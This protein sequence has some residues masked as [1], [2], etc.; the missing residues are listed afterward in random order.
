MEKLYSY[1]NMSYTYHSVL[2]VA[3]FEINKSIF[4]LY[5]ETVNTDCI[6]QLMQLFE[7]CVKRFLIGCNRLHG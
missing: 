5:Y 7:S 6:M 4:N 3:D 2:H 1:Q